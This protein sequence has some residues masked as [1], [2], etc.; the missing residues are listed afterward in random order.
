MKTLWIILKRINKLWLI[1]TLLHI[2]WIYC[3]KI[4]WIDKP[5]YNEFWVVTGEIYFVIALSIIAGYV[6][7]LFTTEVPLIKKRIAFNGLLIAS[8]GAIES[9]IN[10]LAREFGLTFNKEKLDDLIYEITNIDLNSFYLTRTILYE[11]KANNEF[12]FQ[13]YLRHLYDLTK[14]INQKGREEI[15]KFHIFSFLLDSSFFTIASQFR[16]TKSLD[17]IRLKEFLIIQLKE[18]GIESVEIEQKDILF[19]LEVCISKNIQLY[20]FLKSEFSKYAM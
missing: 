18:F 19:L 3:Y 20:K 8:F 2:I 7:Y 6:I 4:L 16:A 10:N 9:S 13:N 14:S 5:A 17:F 15:E 1:F 11:Q 12:T